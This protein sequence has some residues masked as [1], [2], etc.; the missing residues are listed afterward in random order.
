MATEP[1]GCLGLI[2]SLF[3]LSS[4]TQ[5]AAPAGLPDVRVNRYFVSDAEASFF[6]VLRSVVGDRGH[7]LAQVSLRQL[8]WLPGNSRSNPGR[9]TWQN[10]VAARTVDFVVCHP[11]TLQPLVVIELDEPSHAEARRQTRDEEVEAMLRK[12][13]MPVLRVLTSRGYSTRELAEAILPYLDGVGR[14]GGRA[15]A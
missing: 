12:A 11:A 15:H 9:G 14:R 6:R 8:L 1:R 7:V 10:K 2:L 4:R 5:G 13:D 3:G